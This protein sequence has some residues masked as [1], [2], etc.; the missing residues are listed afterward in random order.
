MRPRT[1]LTTKSHDKSV[2]TLLRSQ[3][4]IYLIE[5]KEFPVST[6]PTWAVNSILRN[7]RVLRKI[8][9]LSMILQIL[10]ILY[11]IANATCK[12]I[13]INWWWKYADRDITW[14]YFSFSHWLCSLLTLSNFFLRWS[15]KL[16]GWAINVYNVISL[17]DWNKVLLSASVT[18][19]NSKYT[20]L[21]QFYLITFISN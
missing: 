16:P 20:D 21:C 9:A 6:H 18:S 5:E 1:I 14:S 15:I 2:G 8:L 13:F 4:C 10:L 19:K 7:P 3:V 12:V 11:W 17:F